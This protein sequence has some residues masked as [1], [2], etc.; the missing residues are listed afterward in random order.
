MQTEIY[1]RDH[2]AHSS[3]REYS[4]HV[5]VF[6][7][8]FLVMCQFAGAEEG[9]QGG[10]AEGLPS[11]QFWAALLGDLQGRAAGAGQ[12]GKHLLPNNSHH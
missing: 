4:V 9:C 3:Q 10:Q 7:L 2:K 6:V 12:R 5:R 1:L 11:A 8:D